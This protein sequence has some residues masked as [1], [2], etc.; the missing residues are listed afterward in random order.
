MNHH[1]HTFLDDVSF[2]KCLQM[3]VDYLKNGETSL[4]V[5]PRDIYIQQDKNEWNDVMA[6]LKDDDMNSSNPP[7]KNYC[8]RTKPC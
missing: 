4:L 7:K 6:Y 5:D 3:E 2:A 1:R 8:K